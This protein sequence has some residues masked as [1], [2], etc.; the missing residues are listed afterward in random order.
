MCSS[1]LSQRAPVTDQHLKDLEGALDRLDAAPAAILRRSGHLTA[2]YSRCLSVVAVRDNSADVLSFWH[3]NF[4]IRNTQARKYQ[5]G[6]G[7]HRAPSGAAVGAQ[8]S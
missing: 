8:R 6:I 4:T 2:H 3:R 7:G 1:D 5:G